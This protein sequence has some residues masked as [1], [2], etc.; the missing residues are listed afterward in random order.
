M[1]FWIDDIHILYNNNDVIPTNKMTSIEKINSITRLCIYSFIIFYILNMPT[2]YM[3]L[4]YSVFVSMIILYLFINNTINE[5]YINTVGINDNY[6]TNDRLKIYDAY[7]DF[8]ELYDKINMDRLS[9]YDIVN[10]Q[11]KF[12]KACYEFPPTCKT[13]QSHCLNYNDY[14][15]KY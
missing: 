8:D 9:S 15:T 2:K 6:I 5:H 10:D 1:T 14:R 3:W 13:H 12:G 4:S 7:K 11:G